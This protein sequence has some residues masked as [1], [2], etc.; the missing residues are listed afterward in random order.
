MG[1]QCLS[2][3]WPEIS[4]GSSPEHF[5]APLFGARWDMPCDISDGN[6]FMNSAPKSCAIGLVNAMYGGSL[7]VW[8]ATTISRDLCA[9]DYFGTQI[10]SNSRDTISTKAKEVTVTDVIFHP[11]TVMNNMM[12]DHY[13]RQTWHGTFTFVRCNVS[14]TSINIMTT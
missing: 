11:P 4:P 10:D 5:T 13:N 12:E 8:P 9:N 14:Q 7:W 2:K 6:F 1:K 3:C